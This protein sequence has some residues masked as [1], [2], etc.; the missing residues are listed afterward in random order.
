MPPI[1]S[2]AISFADYREA[3][4]ELDITF[5]SGKIYT[6][7]GVPKKVYDDFI[8]SDSAGTYYNNN[9]IRDVYSIR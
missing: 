4:A 5:K 2:T 7:Y 1:T 6:Y 8:S 3:L 9:N